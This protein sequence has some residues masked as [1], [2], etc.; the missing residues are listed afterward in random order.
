MFANVRMKEAG[1]TE[2][3]TKRTNMVK[4][5]GGSFVLSLII[6]FNLAEFICPEADFTFGLFVGAAADIGWVVMSMG[7]VYLFEK[8]S[9]RLF[10]INAGYQAITFTVMGG[11]LGLWN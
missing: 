5:I 10:L 4:L 8:R 2:E 11:I 1:L 6:S 9:M 7:I 3:D